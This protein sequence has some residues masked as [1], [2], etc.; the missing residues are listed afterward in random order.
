MSEE[1]KKK[2]SPKKER[3]RKSKRT[4][5]KK[6]KE[7]KNDAK[8]EEKPDLKRLFVIVIVVDQGIS[9]AVEKYVQD[10]GS[11]V[12]FTFSGKGTASTD[13]LNIMGAVDNT[14]GVVH[15][16][17]NEDKLENAMNEIGLFFNESKKNRGVAFAIPFRSI[18]GVRLYKYL[19]QT[20]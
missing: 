7:T 4:L 15:A 13:L 8:F 10:L 2:E 9:K 20:I 3:S 11:T 17:I 14:K 6:E 12:Q 16:I 19:T 1:E 18:E 5:K